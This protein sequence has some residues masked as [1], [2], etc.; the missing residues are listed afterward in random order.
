MVEASRPTLTREAVIDAARAMIESDGLDRVSLRKLAGTLGVTA[1]ALYA[2]VEDKGDLLRS[3]AEEA[4]AELTARFEDIDDADPIERLR[5][6]SRAYV[7]VAVDQPELFRTMF[8]FPPELGVAEPTGVELAAATRAFDVPR[9]AIEEAMDAGVLRRQD[10][11]MAALT[12]WTATHGVA[13]VLLMG[14][15]FDAAGRDELVSLALDTVLRGLR[16]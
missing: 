9:Q 14:F 15:G 7:D 12:L 2:Y 8:L 11:A 1:P 16:P 5:A 10:P 4:F 3:V 13:D 6:Y